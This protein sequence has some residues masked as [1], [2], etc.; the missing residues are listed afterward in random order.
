MNRILETAVMRARVGPPVYKMDK[1]AGPALPSR[2]GRVGG[3]KKGG[4]QLC[5]NSEGPSCSRLAEMVLRAGERCPEREV[6]A[7]PK[8]ASKVALFGGVPAGTLFLSVVFF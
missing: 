8:S 3:S 1:I 7:T 2:P 6:G 4:W 5:K